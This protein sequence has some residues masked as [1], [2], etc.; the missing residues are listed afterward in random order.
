MKNPFLFGEVVTGTD[1]ADRKIELTD[2][3]R[4]MKNG[5]RV[6]LISPRRYGK[7]SL[8]IN[9]LEGLQKEGIFTAYIDL[10]K[11]TSLRQFLE[12]YASTI[13]RSVESSVERV[14]RLVKD[15]LPGIRPNISV[16]PDGSTSLSIE[17]VEQ[18]HELWRLQE[19]VYDIAERLATKKKRLFVV[20]LDEFQE[21]AQFDGSNVEKSMRAVFQRH[22]NV[23]YLFAGSKRHLIYDMISDKSRAF[24]KMGRVLNLGKIPRVE[25]IP[26]LMKR[27]H[28][29]GFHIEEGVLDDILDITEEY[30]YNVQFL[31]HELW[32]AFLNQK[33]V[34]RGDVVPT[35][36]RLLTQETPLYA[37][38]WDGL[39]LPQRRVLQVI[40]RHGGKN[41]FSREFLTIHNLGASSSVFT[42]VKLLRKKEIIDKEKDFYF[43]TDVFFKE[44]IK[45]K[46]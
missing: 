11:V 7:T 10:Y 31:C 5:E 43:I 25:F 13:T 15:I 24:Y 19:K 44:W 36:E 20:A 37:V 39:P 1:F 40:A 6:F 23:A 30:P 26:F 42:S 46:M 16:A 38:I 18:E 4:N 17:Y 27:F 3:A 28:K 22:K 29:T 33:V 21:C 35:L 45:R 41:L 2:L 34:R 32:D 12:L 9:L 14:V 8:I